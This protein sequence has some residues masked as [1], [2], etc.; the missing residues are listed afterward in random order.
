MQF[1]QKNF[2]VN[3]PHRIKSVGPS[4]IILARH[5]KYLPP[6]FATYSKRRVFLSELDYIAGPKSDKYLGN[7]SFN[8]TYS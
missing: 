7:N 2:L 6:K 5:V 3:L 8:Y 1:K 4:E